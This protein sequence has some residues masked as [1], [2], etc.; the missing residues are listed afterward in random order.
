MLSEIGKENTIPE[1][2]WK[3]KIGIVPKEWRNQY[4]NNIFSEKSTNTD[5]IE[6]DLYSLT[7]ENG[8]CPKTKRYER[9]FLIKKTKDVYKTVE[10]GDFVYNPMNLRFGALARYIGG[11]KVCVSGYYNIFETKKDV[12]AKFMEYY[13]VSERMINYYN[14]MSTGSLN[15]KKRVHFSSFVKFSIPLPSLEEQRKIA[16]ILSL[17]DELINL[18][19]KLIWEKKKQKKYLM[20]ALLNSDDVYFKRLEGFDGQWETGKLRDFGKSYNGLTNKTKNDFG[21]GSAYLSYRN[22]FENEFTKFQ[23]DDLVEVLENENQNKVVYG[24]IL[25]TVSS[26]T[27]KEVAFSS[28]YL[29]NKSMYLNSFCFGY[30]LNNFDVLNPKF[31][32]YYLRSEYFR[33]KAYRLAQGSTRYNISKTNLLNEQ[34]KYPS[35]IEQN[36]IYQ[37]LDCISTEIKVLNNEL[38]MQKQ[39]KKAFMQVLLTGKIRTTDLS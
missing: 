34:V 9:S 1:G 19:E 18:K 33:K 8:V 2:Y 6:L 32:G 10:N 3:S 39:R 36:N 30:R 13:L 27:A 16:K 15:E 37:I 35:L 23:E 7:I 11:K 5:G 12:D 28:V 26:E 20:R 14:R 21:S 31:M 25:F 17:Q 38:D 24:D 29:S 4:F 22:I